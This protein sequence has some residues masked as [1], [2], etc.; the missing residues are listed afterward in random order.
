MSPNA[1]DHGMCGRT[2][3]ADGIVGNLAGVWRL[4]L[5]TLPAFAYPDSC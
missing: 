4:R 1:I 2:G 3:S 5:S